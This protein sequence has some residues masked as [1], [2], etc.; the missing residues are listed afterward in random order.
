[1][2]RAGHLLSARS[3][4]PIAGHDDPSQLRLDGTAVALTSLVGDSGGVID[5]TNGLDR[6]EA[7][8]VLDGIVVPA[9]TPEP[10]ERVVWHAGTAG[11]RTEVRG[12][13]SGEVVSSTVTRPPVPATPVTDKV[14]ALTFD[15]GP[16]PDTPDFVAVLAAKQVTAT[17]CM[18]GRQV[19]VRPDIAKLVVAAGMT[20]C[21]HTFDHNEHLS[22]ATP[23]VVDADLQRGLDAEKNVLGQVPG[24]YRPPGGDL[25]A[26]IE[27][28]AT[29]RGE[30]VI[31]WSVDPSDY[32]RA[33]AQV[34]VDQIMTKVAPGAIILL[35]DGGGD[36]SQTLAALPVL[37]D[38]LRAA[39]YGFTTPAG[40][41]APS[42]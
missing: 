9:P 40:I 24:L 20:L 29:A 25:S 15:D 27:H 39:G 42:G 19:L 3:H 13:V 4:T 26:Q 16:W 37:I 41:S 7:T 11:T 10:V 17:F 30:Q 1:M 36:R 21:N 28:S 35:H 31:G 23:A 34:I 33:P 14:V 22:R 2:P 5:V 18:I 12:A 8:T 38:Q 32:R 6:I